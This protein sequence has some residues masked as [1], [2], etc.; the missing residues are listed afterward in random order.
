MRRVALF[1]YQL[2]LLAFPSKHRSVYGREMLEDFEL[3]LA[4]RRSV[5]PL[6][7][8]AC[9]DAIRAGLGER[10]RY[11]RQ[12][13]FAFVGRDLG[14]AIRALMKAPTFCLVTVLSIGIG[15]G[16]VIGGVTIMRGMMATP[17]GVVVDGLVELLVIP[18]GSLLAQTGKWAIET[19]TYPDFVDLQNAAKG[20]TISGWATEEST[21]RLKDG[22]SVRMDAAY[23]SPNYFTTIGIALA[24]GPGF[25]QSERSSL[26]EAI[27][28]YDVWQN[29]FGSDPDI[30][31][32]SI[33]VN[34]VP[35]VI[36][37]VAPVDF[38]GH[39]APHRHT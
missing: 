21:V 34:G 11:Q 23:V 20:M 29:R 8:A 15:I 31:G 1:V 14:H 18:K 9:L 4:A 22:E 17:P 7:T 12:S 25:H 24:R 38:R 16:A 30:I 19:W 33:V 28:R 39:L 13:A 36:A 27:I 5:F 35:Y 32:S 6:L 26:P 10:R 37:G 2:A 3:T